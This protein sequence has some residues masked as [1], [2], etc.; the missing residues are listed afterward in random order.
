MCV[1]AGRGRS[2]PSRC[3][4]GGWTQQRADSGR[5]IRVE[6]LWRPQ[7]TAVWPWD[8]APPGGTGVRTKLWAPGPERRRW[9]TPG[10][11]RAREPRGSADPSAERGRARCP[12][13][14]APTGPLDLNSAA[15]GPPGS[16]AW[17]PGAGCAFAVRESFRPP[18][19]TPFPSLEG[20]AHL[21]VR[22]SLRS[23]VFCGHGAPAGRP[24]SPPP[25]CSF[26]V[27]WGR[28]AP[29]LRTA[30]GLRGC[31]WHSAPCGCS[32]PQRG[33]T[34]RG[35]VSVLAARCRSLTLRIS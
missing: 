18:R 14:G 35:P 9:A 11:T 28:V 13:G 20:G 2:A 3:A 1:A 16:A 30:G 26:G 24:A 34:S 33:S 29:L 10:A 32:T 7:V 4:S 8:V 17:E 15:A 22:G 23:L 19:S 31:T 27:R 6:L 5:G 12:G 25:D 21:G